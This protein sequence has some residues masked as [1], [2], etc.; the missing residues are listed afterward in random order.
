MTHVRVMLPA[1]SYMGVWIGT[2]GV[3]YFPGCLSRGAAGVAMTLPRPARPSV[4]LQSFGHY[5]EPR[6]R[7]R[8]EHPPSVPL[9]CFGHCAV[10][11]WLDSLQF[12]SKAPWSTFD[13]SVLLQWR[14]SILQ[15]LSKTY[16]DFAVSLQF[17]SKAPWSTFDPSVPLQWR[18]SVLQ[19]LSKTYADFAV[20][21]QFLSKAPWSTFDPSVPL[22]WRTSVLQFLSKT[23]ADFAGFSRVA[24]AWPG[25]A[26]GGRGVNSAP[27]AAI[28]AHSVRWSSGAMAAALATLSAVAMR[29]F[30]PDM[31]LVPCRNTF[32]VSSARSSAP[33]GGCALKHA[34]RSSSPRRAMLSNSSVDIC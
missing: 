16:A 20:S 34:R 19:F 1:A 30:S 27:L 31:R 10:H 28:C 14:T 3:W 21:L 26:R 23:Y 9:Q 25:R 29:L 5:D 7:R 18:T 4:P 24:G 33:L 6:Y 12:L 8:R 22:Q 17:L 15:F 2:R 13:L 11:Q 32:S